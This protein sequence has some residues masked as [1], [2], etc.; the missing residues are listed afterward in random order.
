M[1]YK[2]KCQYDTDQG[3]WRYGCVVNQLES[4]GFNGYIRLSK[5]P[6]VNCYDQ[7]GALYISSRLVGITSDFYFMG[8]FGM[9]KP[10]YLVGYDKKCNNPFFRNFKDGINSPESYMEPYVKDEKIVRTGFWNHAFVVYDA[11]VYDACARPVIGKSKSQYFNDTI[12]LKYHLAH[13]DELCGDLMTL[14]RSK[15]TKIPIL[16]HD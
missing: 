15:C 16:I 7:A 11:L 3:A 10:T 14:E 6:I 13:P 9:I 12:D 2:H 4:F 1:F 8:P 5:G